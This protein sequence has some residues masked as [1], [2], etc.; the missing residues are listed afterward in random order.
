MDAIMVGQLGDRPLGAVGLADRASFLLAMITVGAAN[1]AGTLGAQQ[2]GAGDGAAFRRSIASGVL[3]CGVLGVLSAAFFFFCSPWVVGLGSRDEELVRLGASFLS[4]VGISQASAGILLPLEV[5][6]R[7][8]QR[9]GVATLYS[10]VEAVL[11]FL[12]NY[13]LIFGNWGCPELGVVGAAWGTL[14]ARAVHVVLLVVHVFLWERRVAITLSDLRAAWQ[15]PRLRAFLDIALPLVANHIIWGAG[16]FAFQLL[17]GH[18]GTAPLAAMTVIWTMQRLVLVQLASIGHAGAVLV[19]HAIGRGEPAV[20]K[21]LAWQNVSVAVATSALLAF[22]LFLFRDVAI[23]AFSGLDRA[24]V[25]LILGVF[26]VFLVEAMF[27]ALTVSS[28]V[29]GLK[30][31]GD[32]R[33]ALWIDLAGAWFVGIP[34]AAAGAFLFGLPLPVV[35][36]LAIC[37][38]GSKA[39][40]ALWRLSGTRWIR[41]LAYAAG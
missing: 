23:S 20:A 40:V 15:W 9:A 7:C 34:L 38:E 22:L 31:G 21:R 30:A 17:Y 2:L 8:I 5:G 19:G 13:A 6:L 14:T 18:M 28:I 29:G 1:A 3:M 16:V 32:V 26:P 39:V 33:S 11:N 10:A 37:E 35:Y 41:Q 27:R 25:A 4:I 12:L 36:G 24:T